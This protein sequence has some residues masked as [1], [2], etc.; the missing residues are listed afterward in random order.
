MAPVAGS[1]AE[2]QLGEPALAIGLLV[3]D[4]DDEDN[5]LDDDEDDDADGDHGGKT[6]T[7]KR[8][9]KTMTTTYQPGGRTDGP[10]PD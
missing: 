8:K 5:D 9:T 6:R 4:A 1:P 7:T 3:Q 10:R 2:E